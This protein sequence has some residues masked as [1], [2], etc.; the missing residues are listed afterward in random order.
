MIIDECT[1]ANR[2]SACDDQR[3]HR[4]PFHCSC[5]FADLPPKPDHGSM[6][7][8]T[9]MPLSN[10]KCNN[11]YTVV[12][13]SSAWPGLVL[14]SDHFC[15]GCNTACSGVCWRQRRCLRS[16]RRESPTSSA[17]P[18]TRGLQTLA[19]R[20]TL[21]CRALRRT[22]TQRPQHG[23][24][25]P[26]RLCGLF[27]LAAA[28]DERPCC[29][30]RS[31]GVSVVGLASLASGSGSDSWATEHSRQHTSPARHSWS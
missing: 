21:R 3:F 8:R 28:R 4:H 29:S 26:L 15:S 14:T 31:T 9:C 24:A 20:D 6:R 12:L 11:Y 10:P 16:V 22:G 17:L 1:V 2:R 18:P 19:T 7:C 5:R 25:L 23:I 30:M 13:G 27:G